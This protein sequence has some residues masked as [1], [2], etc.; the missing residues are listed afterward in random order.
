M[1]V[2]YHACLLCCLINILESHA[3]CKLKGVLVHYSILG[4]FED[5]SDHCGLELSQATLAAGRLTDGELFQVHRAGV[6][7]VCPRTGN[8][9][10][11]I[12]KRLYPFLVKNN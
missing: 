12:R 6:V 5:I 3:Q 11:S 9:R 2:I 1:S 4:E 8:V 7:V 10:P